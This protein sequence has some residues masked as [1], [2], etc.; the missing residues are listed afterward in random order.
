VPDSG[1]TDNVSFYTSS[2]H[3][4][5]VRQQVVTTCTSATRPS[6]V[7]GR[8]IY[9]TDTDL[10]LG[11]NGSAWVPFAGPSTGWTSYTPT[12]AQGATPNIAKT[13]VR[14]RWCY[15]GFK[16]VTWTFDLALT[17]S[18]TAGSKVTLTL[19]VTAASA[20]GVVGA[21][22]ILDTGAAA[23]GGSWRGAS[24]TTVQFES[25]ATGFLGWGNT[26]SIALASGDNL[27]GSITYEIA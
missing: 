4:T 21:G 24:T 23:Y 18:G 27:N 26:P 6:A 16:T 7:E 14:S 17:A 25:D 3:D 22:L 13:V 5:Y 2:F 10:L 20:N 12:V 19:P 1:L 9:E 15:T 8:V 11:Y